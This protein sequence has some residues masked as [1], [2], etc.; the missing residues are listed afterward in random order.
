LGRGWSWS[1]VEVSGRCGVPWRGGWFS[2][3]AWVVSG[4][5]LVVRALV[6][7]W[8]AA[9]PVVA[10]RLV[11]WWLVASALVVLW[12]V[13]LRLRAPVAVDRG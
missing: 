5:L 1:V 7:R 11:P 3:L 2:R 13:I 10:R 4:W 8:L 6:R 12:A 9:R